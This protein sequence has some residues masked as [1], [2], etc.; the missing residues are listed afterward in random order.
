MAH[1]KVL[2]YYD[3]IAQFW[4]MEYADMEVA[5]SVAAAVSVPRSGGYALDIGC[6]SGSM[7]LDLLQYGACEIE[8]VD[9]SGAMI[10]MAQEKF[11]FDPRISFTQSDFMDLDRP[12]Y[13]LAVAFNVYHHFLCPKAFVEK[14]H[15][16]LRCGG[17]LTVAYGFSR[18][19]TNQLSE[20]MPNGI[21]R[22][23]RPAA[24][25]AAVWSTHFDVDILCDTSEMYLI[26]G[27]ALEL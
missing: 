25:E 26:S 16:L 7:I 17:R 11:Y 22:L 20:V 9:I 14:A 18:K 4:D 24:E 6:G 5:R 3:A 12:G 21:A 13:D 1:T 19:Q 23:L 15:S 2:E 27:R 8:G 10:E